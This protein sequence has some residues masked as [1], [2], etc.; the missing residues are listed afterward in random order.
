MEKEYLSK[1][2][3]ENK[4]KLTKE[5]YHRLSEI[6]NCISKV[7]GSVAIISAM[8][9]VGSAIII[10]HVNIG[11]MISFLTSLCA[12]LISDRCIEKKKDKVRKQ[13]LNTKNQL[14]DI[15]SMDFEKKRYKLEKKYSKVSSKNKL[16]R[17]LNE[18]IE[19]LKK[20][21]EDLNEYCI[22][23]NDEEIT[24]EINTRNYTLQKLNQL[25]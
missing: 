15:V 21:K 10:N 3:L 2:E 5:Q 19:L 11:Y 8:I 16:E 9:M 6:G 7:C 12:V 22:N 25:K 23:K 17:N 18:E 20:Y 1:K 13:Y 4:L 24:N 14:E